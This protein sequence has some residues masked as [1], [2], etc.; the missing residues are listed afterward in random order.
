MTTDRVRRFIYYCKMYGAMLGGSGRLTT[1]TMS[2]L[3][4]AC[5]QFPE[6]YC[7]SKYIRTGMIS[8]QTRKWKH[9]K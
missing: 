9:I 7:I 4:D 2:K 6:V 1:S 3:G 5:G 8:N